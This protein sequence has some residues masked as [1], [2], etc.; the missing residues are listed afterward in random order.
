MDLQKAIFGYK[1]DLSF[2]T[3]AEIWIQ[4]LCHVFTYFLQNTSFL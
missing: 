4:A 1:M 3:Q 2:L